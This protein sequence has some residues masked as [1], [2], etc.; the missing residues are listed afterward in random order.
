M[1]KLPL[2]TT[3]LVEGLRYLDDVE[4]IDEDIVGCAARSADVQIMY[5]ED[6]W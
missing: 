3:E 1:E 4:L 5:L 2:Q 6:E